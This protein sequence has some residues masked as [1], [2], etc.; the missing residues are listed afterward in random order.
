MANQKVTKN[1]HIASI[2][3]I[4]IVLFTLAFNAGKQSK[5]VEFNRDAN[6][7]TVELIG[8]TTGLIG[9]NAGEIKTNNASIMGHI[10]EIRERLA[11][12]EAIQKQ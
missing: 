10:M 6:A 9:K 3:T 1:I 2:I 7:A 12:I 11:A 5:Q 8:E 4:L